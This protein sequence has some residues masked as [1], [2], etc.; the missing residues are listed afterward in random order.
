[1]KKCAINIT[2]FLFLSHLVFEAPVPYFVDYFKFTML[3]SPIVSFYTITALILI[4]E[5]CKVQTYQVIN[6]SENSEEDS[7]AVVP[8]SEFLPREGPIRKNYETFHRIQ[9]RRTSEKKKING[10]AMCPYQGQIAMKEEC[11]RYFV[12]QRC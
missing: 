3:Y 2:L 9:A 6:P 8:L 10:L 1:M 12:C 4:F 11:I 7:E 5:S